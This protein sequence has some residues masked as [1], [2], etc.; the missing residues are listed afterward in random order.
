LLLQFVVSKD[1]TE[2]EFVPERHVCLSAV[3]GA[4]R[5]VDARDATMARTHPRIFARGT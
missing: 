4:P 1:R 3:C 2:H 5:V